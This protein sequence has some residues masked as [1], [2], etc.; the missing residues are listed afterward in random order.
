M[1]FDISFIF[2]LTSA[3]RMFVLTMRCNKMFTLFS[4]LSKQGWGRGSRSP[5][6]VNIQRLGMGLVKVKRIHF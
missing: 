6:R 5:I 1:K 2:A 3:A 4:L